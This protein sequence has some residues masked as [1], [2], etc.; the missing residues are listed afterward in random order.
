LE[1]EAT[2]GTEDQKALSPL[3]LFAPVEFPVSS[4]VTVQ[5]ASKSVSKES[6][7]FVYAASVAEEENRV[8]PQVA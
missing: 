4:V 6:R 5:G 2:E 8:Q 3:P 1:Q 7:A